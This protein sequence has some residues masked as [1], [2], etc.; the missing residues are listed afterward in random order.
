MSFHAKRKNVT[1]TLRIV[2][3]G[4]SHQKPIQIQ[5]YYTRQ[6][7]NA[8]NFNTSSKVLGT[9]SFGCSLLVRVEDF[10]H[11]TALH[12]RRM[13][14]LSLDLHLSNTKK[15]LCPWVLQ[16]ST[17]VCIPTLLIM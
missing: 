8:L 13:E 2:P 7:E 14:R 6:R 10:Q 11:D 17:Y 9:D 12:Y 15:L 4:S 1:M 5:L 3:D 16:T